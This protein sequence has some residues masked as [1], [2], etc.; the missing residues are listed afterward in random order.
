M[1][2]GKD[3]EVLHGHVTSDEIAE[4]ARGVGVDVDLPVQFTPE[5]WKTFQPFEEPGIQ[6]LIRDVMGW[7]VPD[8][9]MHICHWPKGNVL[10]VD[11][12]GSMSSGQLFDIQRRLGAARF[13]IYADY[14]HPR[15]SVLSIAF[16]PSEEPVENEESSA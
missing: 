12:T 3:L 10:T 2:D 11:F 5:D 14:R 8:S 4:F 15:S 16:H 6:D 1:A 9:S 13:E 7:A